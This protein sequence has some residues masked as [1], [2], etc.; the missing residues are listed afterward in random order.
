MKIEQIL[1]EKDLRSPAL[2]PLSLSPAPS[3]LLSAPQ[4]ETLTPQFT[5]HSTSQL[6]CYSSSNSSIS[7]QFRTVT[8]AAR[9]YNPPV[10]R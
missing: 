10:G 3:V 4:S 8:V 1:A 2:S 5:L 6:A 9:P 7:H